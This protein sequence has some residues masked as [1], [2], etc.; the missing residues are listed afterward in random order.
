MFNIIYVNHKRVLYIWLLRNNLSYNK[1]AFSRDLSINLENECFPCM[2]VHIS[3]TRNTVAF[4]Y[5][6]IQI[7]VYF[8]QLKSGVASLVEQYFGSLYVNYKATKNTLIRQARDLLVCEYNGSLQKFEM[9]FC[10]PANKLL[11]FIKVSS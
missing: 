4:L 3:F 9:E 5:S 11:Q 7:F 10:R 1:C 2:Y 8:L 6:F